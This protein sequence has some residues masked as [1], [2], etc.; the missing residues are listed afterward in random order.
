MI[1][2]LDRME[3]RIGTSGFQYPEWR[4]KFYP[5]NLSTAKMLGF[6]TGRFS[7]TES[8]YS[9]RRI[10]SENTIENWREKTPPGFFFSLKAPQK[11]TH[12]AKLRDC[13]E[14]I[15]FFWRVTSGLKEKMGA[16]LFQLPATHRRDLPVLE[17]FLEI[18]PP[19]MRAAFEFRHESWFT[20]DVFALL[21]ERNAALC[22]AESAELATPPTATTSFGYLRLR[23]EDYDA[24]RL[25]RWAEWIRAQ[26][27]DEVFIYFK[28]EEKAVGPE[29]ARR[30]Q[31]LLA[32]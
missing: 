3:V 31:E 9:F 16:I 18:L 29:F 14:I 2:G 6:Y 24:A 12:V 7:T 25:A 13:R 26:A 19:A 28:H 10:P 32:V 22:V 4:G 8:H 11:I 27:W 30:M 5:E 17:D 15:E 20:E 21:R 23:R 1:S